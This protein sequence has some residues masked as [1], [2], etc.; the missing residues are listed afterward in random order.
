MEQIKTLEE[1]SGNGSGKK[2]IRKF[3]N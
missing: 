2:S 1:V 3:V